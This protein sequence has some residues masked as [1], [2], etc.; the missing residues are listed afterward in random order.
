VWN[1]SKELVVDPEQFL[2]K[3]RATPFKGRKLN[4]ECLLTVCDGVVVYK[5]D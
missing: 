2:S 4:G 3:G 1:L 5:K